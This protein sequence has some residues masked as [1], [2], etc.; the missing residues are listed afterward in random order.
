MTRN[1]ILKIPCKNKNNGWTKNQWSV[2][3]GVSLY[4]AIHMRMI[5]FKFSEKLQQLVKPITFNLL[6]VQY[7]AKNEQPVLA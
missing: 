5:S 1:V 6:R 7:T 4:S 3:R 2:V